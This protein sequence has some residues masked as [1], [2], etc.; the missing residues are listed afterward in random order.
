MTPTS[1]PNP[2][3]ATTPNNASRIAALVRSGALKTAELPMLKLALRNH[4][5]VN[6][7]TARLPRNQRIVLDRYHTAISGAAVSTP[8]SFAAVRKNISADY[9]IDR[10]DFINEEI[11]RDPPNV[12]VL[13]RQGIRLFPDGRR[14]ALYTNK[15]LGIAISV[16]YNTKGG[17]ETPVP[18]VSEE[19]EPV[20]ENIKL[21]QSVV[22]KGQ[23]QILTFKNGR[24]KKIDNQTAKHIM[25][26]HGALND[27]NK[28]KVEDMISKS[29]EH[30]Q[31]V[32]DFAQ[33][34]TKYV[35]NK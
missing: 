4:A 32:L 20:V 5:S 28:K 13:K 2:I 16:P 15:D 6:F 11:D 3:P 18:A 23:P 19:V 22:N 27:S 1:H 25:A 12:L 17:K 21:I 26:V 14:V 8:S 7:D 35:V 34:H 10:T 33:K 9:E 29:P 24:Q 31:K 30:L